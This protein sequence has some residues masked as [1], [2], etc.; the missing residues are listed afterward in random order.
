MTFERGTD[1]PRVILVGASGSDASWRAVAYATGLARRQGA[2]LVLLYVQ[3]VPAMAATTGLGA[4]LVEMTRSVAEQICDQVR[5]GLATMD[6]G[7]ALRWEFRTVSGH[8]V[9]CL[10]QTACELHADAV[11]IGTSR[12]M[13]RRL[14]GSIAAR[15]VRSGRWPVTVVP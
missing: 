5:A 1:G 12:R 8:V 3:P 7:S 10:S 14:P 11:V 15:L 6:G 4:A 13:G 2:M 9:T